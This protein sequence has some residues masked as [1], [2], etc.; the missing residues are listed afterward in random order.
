MSQDN[1]DNVPNKDGT[2]EG[3]IETEK[4]EIKMAL[5]TGELV[6]KFPLPKDFTNLKSEVYNII[7]LVY[8]KDDITLNN[9]FSCSICGEL[10]YVVRTNG[11]AKLR[12]HKCFVKWK[13]QQKPHKHVQSFDDETLANLLAKVANIGEAKTL[14]TSEHIRPIL[15]EKSS[16]EDW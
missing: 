7:Q 6:A 4:S 8:E 5:E 10:M 11:T 3:T 15:P 2:N 1:T 13:E 9:W 12:R 16:P 14:I